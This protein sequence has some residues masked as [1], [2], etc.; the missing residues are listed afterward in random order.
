MKIRNSLVSN[1]SSSS[2]IIIGNDISASL[3]DDIKTHVANKIIEIDEKG[4]TQFGWDHVK[5]N[6]FWDRLNF[7]MI[8]I[9][10]L[11]DWKNSVQYNML[12]SVLKSMLDV[13]FINNKL[14]LE[15][16]RDS[17][18]LYYSYI[19]H[20]SSIAEGRNDGMFEDETTLK[21][22][23]FSKE[24]YIQGGNDNED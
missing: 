5:Y 2:F 3:I 6:T 12:K 10:Y 7:T 19:D 18:V 20:Q 21:Q 4:E 23:L 17:Y 1:S 15:Y 9:M 8:Q 11:K 13:D 22:F 24:S 16:N 14:T